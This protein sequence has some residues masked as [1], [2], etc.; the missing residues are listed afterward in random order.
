MKNVI[1]LLVIV[2]TFVA[3]PSYAAQK[4]DVEKLRIEL[5]K[6]WGEDGLVKPYD[7]RKKAKVLFSKP[8]E[9]QTISELKKV[10][11]SSNTAANLVEFILEEYE[12]YYRDNYKYDFVQT[13]VA[14]FHD[15]YVELSNELKG[16][17]NKAYFN[18]GKK[19]KAKG[20]SLAALFY[21][22]DAYRLSSF[23]ESEGDHKGMRYNAERELKAL[24]GIDDIP[25]FIYW[26]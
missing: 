21:F 6:K 9:E 10:A 12:D 1:S 15:K 11:K 2:A 14:P 22:R 7:I 17:R 23:T 18:L 16:Y 19:L 24:L 13:K 25:S 26:Q 5:V 20:K 4:E 3:L 8:L